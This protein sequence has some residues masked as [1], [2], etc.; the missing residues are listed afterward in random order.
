M[1]AQLDASSAA[2][3][4]AS[5][6]GPDDILAA[7]M[8]RYWDAPNST[9]ASVRA[10]LDFAWVVYCDDLL[11]QRDE[12]IAR[13]ERAEAALAE[14]TRAGHATPARLPLIKLEALGVGS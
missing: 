6:L 1:S 5:A 14:V 9:V 3:R 7:A 2:G 8:E 10:V 4:P 11:R 12:A 13:A